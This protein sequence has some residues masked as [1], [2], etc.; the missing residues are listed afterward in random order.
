MI[1]P[2]TPTRTHATCQIARQDAQDASGCAT[3][4]KMPRRS[5][6]S[7][8]CWPSASPTRRRGAAKLCTGRS[9]RCAY[10]RVLPCHRASSCAVRTSDE[11][12]AVP[13]PGCGHQA[14]PESAPCACA[15]LQGRPEVLRLN[16]WPASSGGA[17]G[18]ASGG[19]RSG[20]AGP[21]GPVGCIL[22][23]W[24]LRHL[25]YGK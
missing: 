14:V 20:R 8:S 18:G 1:A 15:T 19:W 10:G 13:P 21:P 6:Q 7:A 4:E 3:D 24:H 11:A 5:P 9:S 25:W 12:A 16:R 22:S 23:L 17:S 2:Y